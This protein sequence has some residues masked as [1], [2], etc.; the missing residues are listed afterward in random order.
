MTTKGRHRGSRSPWGRVRV[1]ATRLF[2]IPALVVLTVISSF[3]VVASVLD[4]D[5]PSYLGTFTEEACIDPGIRRS[6]RSVGTWVSDDRTV[7]KLDVF[8]DGWVGPD[9]VVRATY[10]PTGIINDLENNIVHAEYTAPFGPILAWGLFIGSAGGLVIMVLDW[11]R[12]A[13]RQRVSMKGARSS[14]GSPEAPA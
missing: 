4:A 5:E 3:L 1:A 9:G 14:A 8:L 10:T 12:D 7:R 6:C 11:R 2:A 13:G